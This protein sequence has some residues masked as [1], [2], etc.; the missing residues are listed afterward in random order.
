MVIQDKKLI[1]CSPVRYCS[2]IALGGVPI[3]VA[4]PPVFAAIGIHNTKALIPKSPLGADATIGPNNASIITVVAVLD[5]NIE[6]TEVISIKPSMM[7][8]G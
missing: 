5:I 2:A 3:G 4:I 7:N 6:N 1:L 8:F